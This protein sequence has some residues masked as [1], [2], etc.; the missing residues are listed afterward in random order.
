MKAVVVR[1]LGGPE[2]LRLEEAEVP[3][4][5]P[6]EARVRV[7]A[8][9][10]NHLDIWVRAGTPGLPP[11]LP[12]IPGSDAAGVVEA[13]GPGAERW[14]GQ[15]VLIYPGLFCGTCR[16]CLGGRENRCARFTV[17]GG[18]LADGTDREAVVVP[19][20]NLFPKPPGLS[21]E[22]AAA[23]PLV[24][25]TAWHMARV[26]GVR[27]G[28]TVLVNAVGSG[29]GSA[30]V[31]V[32][33]LLGARVM[34]SAGAAWKLERARELGVSAGVDYSAGTE[35]LVEAV[36]EWTGG[37]GVDV[38][39]DCVGGELLTTCLGC[40]ARGGRVVT[41]GATA[42]ARL[43]I[44]HRPLF[45]REISLLGTYLGSREEMQEVL[46]RVADKR[47]RPVVDRVFPL[48]D[49]VEAHRYLESRAN[50]GKVVLSLT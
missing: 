12:R 41:C 1:E 34:G 37:R 9:S 27:E 22:E 36:M 32:A 4:P 28:E 14:I 7:K 30:A 23:F 46:E 10:L 31:Q 19:A 13:A 33:V 47:L 49:V 11:A 8:V 50:F 5:G 42:G 29:V 21:W 39:L 17:I 40:V 6:G 26:A 43:D 3:E 48:E 18:P 16:E 35:G 44:L 25:L 15:E 2:V 38:V 20:G 24:F 45:S